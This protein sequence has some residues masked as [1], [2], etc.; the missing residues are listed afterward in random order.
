MYKK[1]H[2]DDNTMDVCCVR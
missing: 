1:Q 2:Y